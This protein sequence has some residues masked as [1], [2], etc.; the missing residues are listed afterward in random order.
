MAGFFDYLRAAMGWWSVPP[1]AETPANA[2]G[3]LTIE[4]RSRGTLAIEP[5]TKGT[6]KVE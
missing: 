1:A 4:P 5:Q 6:V 3:K 2:F